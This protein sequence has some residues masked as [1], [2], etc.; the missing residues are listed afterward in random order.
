M[1][2][3][4]QGSDRRFGHPSP[5]ATPEKQK[6]IVVHASANE[7]PSYYDFCLPVQFFL[8]GCNLMA[9]LM[10]EGFSTRVGTR[11]LDERNFPG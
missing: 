3:L 6:R 10:Q 2:R 9:L 8:I 5:P 1:T 11:R 4:W 7:M